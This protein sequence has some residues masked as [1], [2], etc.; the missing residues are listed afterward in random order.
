MGITSSISQDE[1]NIIS[2]DTKF[3]II[4]KYNSLEKKL[5]VSNLKLHYSDIYCYIDIPSLSLMHTSNRFNPTY[6]VIEIT[7]KQNQETNNFNIHL[8][9]T[10]DKIYLNQTEK[11]YESSN[12]QNN[13]DV[14]FR[15]DDNYNIKHILIKFYNTII[16]NIE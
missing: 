7:N 5:K 9:R 3:D 12:Y 1:N 13:K 14:I 10:N 6:F 8:Q 2:F 16:G 15:Y 11:L 4:L